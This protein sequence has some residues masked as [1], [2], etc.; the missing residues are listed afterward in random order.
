MEWNFIPTGVYSHIADRDWENDK[1][2]RDAGENP[3]KCDD[4]AEQVSKCRGIIDVKNLW[5]K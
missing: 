2:M 4:I 5:L 3:D 1:I